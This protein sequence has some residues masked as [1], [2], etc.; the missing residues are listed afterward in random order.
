MND[1]TLP[2]TLL[3]EPARN[4]S[5]WQVIAVLSMIWIL[6]MLSTGSHYSLIHQVFYPALLLAGFLLAYLLRQNIRLKH[7]LTQQQTVYQDAL[8]GLPNRTALEKE[9][10]LSVQ[11][12][13]NSGRGVA[14]LF[15]DLDD[16]KPVNDS[17]GHSIGDQMLIE[18]AE[19]LAVCLPKPALLT[20]FGGDEFVV[21]LPDLGESCEALPLVKQLLRVVACNYLIEGVPLQISASIGGAYYDGCQELTANQLIQQADMA[22]Y[23]AKRNGHNQFHWYDKCM[24]TKLH[25]RVQL[26][27]DLQQALDE[28]TMELHYQPLVDASTGGIV[29]VEALLRWEHPEKGYISPADFVPLA[30]ETG[31]IIQLTE[32]T[33]QR[34]CRD[35][36]YLHSLDISQVAVNVSAIQLLKPGFIDSLRK[37]LKIHEIQPGQL[38]VE[39]TENVLL[40]DAELGKQLINE[41]REMGVRVSMD[42]FG[43]GFS[44][45]SYL[46]NLHLDKIKLD[47]C[48]ID[49]IVINHQS[50]MIV[51]TIIRLAQQLGM[52]VVAEGVE[53]GEQATLLKNLGCDY[54]QGFYYSKA[55]RKERL[56]FFNES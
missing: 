29:S 14:L 27:N 45:L 49:D 47:K 53:T 1:R 12:S 22:M 11:T 38:E 50:A 35:L 42:D 33:L 31:Q 46:Q 54:L 32:W 16:F 48:F 3:P 24:E 39:L 2:K 55:I 51:E 5:A 36:H 17:L 23:K 4:L 30:E 7:Q 18:V 41:L 28:E 10:K 9:L 34:A 25:R 26:R 37:L 44:S 52:K 21:V 8:T 56:Q 40:E 15:I 6:M 13:Q 19:R 43:T 20:R